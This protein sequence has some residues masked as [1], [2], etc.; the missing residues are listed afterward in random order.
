MKKNTTI[1]I[2]VGLGLGALVLFI[3]QSWSWLGLQSVLPV[4][5]L[6]LSLIWSALGGLTYAAAPEAGGLFVGFGHL[7]LFTGAIAV[8]MPMVSPFALTDAIRLSNAVLGFLVAA[9]I[10]GRDMVRGGVV[11]SMLACSALGAALGA[12]AS[13][14]G[15]LGEINPRTLHM[16]FGLY[17]AGLTAA[18]GWRHAKA[19]Q[20]Q[21]ERDL[22]AS[23]AL[24][25]VGGAVQTSLRSW[26]KVIFAYAGVEFAFRPLSML[27]L[28]LAVG[29]ATPLLGVGGFIFL[30][31]FARVAQLPTRL[32]RPAA[33]KAVAVACAVQAVVFFSASTATVSAP[34]LGAEAVGLLAA[35]LAGLFYPK[36]TATLKPHRIFLAPAAYFGLRSLLL[37]FFGVRLWP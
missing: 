8:A 16:V 11:P 21:A 4:Q 9:A 18:M 37:A 22:E 34:L 31:L 27:G 3:G 29:L 24:E 30:P 7:T 17:L 20:A 26:R 13:S 6:L 36:L 2:V 14:L 5:I 10:L 25:D 1:L 33:A 12:A 28:G 19:G 15:T 23:A 35:C 32:A